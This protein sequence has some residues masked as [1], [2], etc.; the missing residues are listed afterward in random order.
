MNNAHEISYPVIAFAKGGVVHLARNEADL[1][2]CSK[3]GLANGFYNGLNLIDSEGNRYNILEAR[4]VGYANFLWGFNLAFGQR[5]RVELIISG[6]D[7]AL[8]IEDFKERLLKQLKKDIQ[9]W[10]SGGNFNELTVLI[11]TGKSF[12]DII[13][14]LTNCYYR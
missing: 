2:I 1:T 12:K 11:K 9:F 13:T 10:N 8:A 4:K 3:R 5:I 7:N 14:Y 6:S